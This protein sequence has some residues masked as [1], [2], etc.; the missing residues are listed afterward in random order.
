VD[1]A[2]ALVKKLEERFGYLVNKKV[3]YLLLGMPNFR[4]QR[5]TE[6]SKDNGENI[7]EYRLAVG[8]LLFLLKHSQP[9]LAN[10]LRELSKVLD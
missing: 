7:S 9:C 1:W 2:T 6:E 5:P 10:P 4:I 8:T 3:R